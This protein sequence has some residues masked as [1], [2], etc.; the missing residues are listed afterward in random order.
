MLEAMRRLHTRSSDSRG[1]AVDSNGA[2]L[3]P[4][5][6]LV[7]R[8][9]AGFR[10]L[11]P[12]EAA[13]IQTAA[14]GDEREPGWLFDQAR[15]IADALAKGEVAL[16][17]IYGLRIPVADLDDIRLQRL[18]AASRLVKANFDPGQPRVPAGNPDGGQ[19][20]DTG[21]SEEDT[22]STA[23]MTTKAGPPTRATM[24]VGRR[25]TPARRPVPHPLPTR[26]ER[27]AAE[28]TAPTAKLPLTPA[29]MAMPVPTELVTAA[30]RCPSPHRWP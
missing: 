22:A 2:M 30:M 12:H 4:D 1:V 18:A 10:T 6:V 26:R 8:T 17:Q 16:A 21:G 24:Q 15:R 3:G 19:W 28:A 13:A 11:A 25:P 29:E 9:P 7:R 20:V 5:C 14:L 23:P 27:A